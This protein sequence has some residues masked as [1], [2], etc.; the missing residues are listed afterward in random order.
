MSII[1]NSGSNPSAV[2]FNGT[3]L[4]YVTYNGTTVWEGHDY[5]GALADVGDYTHWRYC[6]RGCGKYRA[7]SHSYTNGVCACGHVKR[8]S[9]W[10]YPYT[11]GESSSA[12]TTVREVSTVTVDDV[13]YT[14]AQCIVVDYGTPWSDVVSRVGTPKL[15]WMLVNSSTIGP[16]SDTRHVNMTFKGWNTDYD[17]GAGTDLPSSGSV[18]GDWRFHP[19]FRP[20]VYWY[21]YMDGNYASSTVWHGQPGDSLATANANKPSW[22]SDITSDENNSLD[23]FPSGWIY[24][25]TRY[26]TSS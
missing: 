9:I 10:F 8:C 12:G 3:P 4:C 5:T 24:R 22:A 18:T 6:S 2:K 7:E 17:K 16:T 11:R 14:A 19:I 20:R 26:R 25:K 1:Y 13:A 15:Q 23:Y 21:S